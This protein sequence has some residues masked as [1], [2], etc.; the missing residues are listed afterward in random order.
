MYYI[1]N[2]TRNTIVNHTDRQLPISVDEQFIQGDDIIIADLFTSTIKVPVGTG[3]DETGYT[4]TL[5]EDYQ[6]PFL[7]NLRETA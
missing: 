3:V 2:K 7:I 6:A 1:I 5:W 4:T